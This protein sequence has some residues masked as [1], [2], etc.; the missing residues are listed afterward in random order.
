MTQVEGGGLVLLPGEGRQIVMGGFD[1][2]ILGTA[3]VTG[4]AY[5]L[6]QTSEPRPGGGPPLHVHR[7]AA[8]SFYVVAGQ[9]TMHLAGQDFDCPAGSYVHIPAG[10]AHTFRVMEADSRKL[11]LYTPSAMEGYFEELGEAID[12]GADEVVLNDIA[13]RY[14]ME[15]VGPAPEGYLS[16]RE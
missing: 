7:D 5:S 9:Y 13:E 10:M 3:G 12:R 4:G 1:I 8:E 2:S 16:Q 15:V 6:V 11:N 14:E